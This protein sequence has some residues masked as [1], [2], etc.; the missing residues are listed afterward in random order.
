MCDGAGPPGA[1]Y[2]S[3]NYRKNVPASNIGPNPLF[4]RSVHGCVSRERTDVGTTRTI[5]S[6]PDGW[7]TRAGRHPLR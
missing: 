5:A 2:A 6:H 1:P 4:R 3:P 7:R